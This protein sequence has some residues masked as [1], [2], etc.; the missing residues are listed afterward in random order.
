MTVELPANNWQG[1]IQKKK[2]TLCPHGV[3]QIT[4][5]V[6]NGQASYDVTVSQA[7]LQVVQLSGLL[8]FC[9]RWTCMFGFLRA[10]CKES[11]PLPSR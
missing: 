5:T 3:L 4:T 6:P 8:G 2:V 1:E 10:L 9:S 11:S 7:D